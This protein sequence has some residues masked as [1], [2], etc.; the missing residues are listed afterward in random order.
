MSNVR[1]SSG[2]GGAYSSLQFQQISRTSRWASTPSSEDVQTLASTPRSLSRV[3]APRASLV[4][5]VLTTRCPVWA[6]RK[7]SSAVS[8]SRISPS[9]MTSGS[10]RRN[11]RV[12]N[13]DDRIL[14]VIAGNDGHAEVHRDDAAV[15]LHAGA[16]AAVLRAPALGDI[17]GCEDLDA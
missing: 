13:A 2:A 14:A 11:A 8:G 3:M 6:A 12:E 1:L 10:W 5:S 15:D 17:E 4:C 7:A 16:E 9:M